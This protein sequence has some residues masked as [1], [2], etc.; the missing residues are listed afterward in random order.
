MTA[1]P[2]GSVER[3]RPWN[4]S[5]GEEQM[6]VSV[7]VLVDWNASMLRLRSISHPPFGIGYGVVNIL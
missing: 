2:S 5:N 7:L 3:L 6:L 4:C 1:D